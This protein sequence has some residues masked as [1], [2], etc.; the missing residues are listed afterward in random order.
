MSF[1]RVTSYLYCDDFN[2]YK[3]QGDLTEYI[4]VYYSQLRFF[5]QVFE[6]I[7]S[8]LLNVLKLMAY[9]QIILDGKLLY[10]T[11]IVIVSVNASLTIVFSGI[12]RA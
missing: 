6:L 5:C 3:P 7:L 1:L 2:S 9:L 11:K 12:Q 8:I 10:N 4:N